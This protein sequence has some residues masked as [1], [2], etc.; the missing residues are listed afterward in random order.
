MAPC[1]RRSSTRSSRRRPV[2]R[3]RRDG[4]GF[5]RST[6][7]AENH[8]SPAGGR[9]APDELVALG[10]PCLLER[11]DQPL[12]R[13]LLELEDIELPAGQ[14][15]ALHFAEQG[16]G[17]GAALEGKGREHAVERLAGTGEAGAVPC[18]ELELA[19][20]TAQLAGARDVARRRVQATRK[21]LEHAAPRLLRDPAVAA[22]HE[23]EPLP[24][25][26]R[27]EVEQ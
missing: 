18:P 3:G 23:Q 13:L 27:S 10:K 14:Q 15:R 8:A 11:R 22:L 1:W 26:D 20:N 4:D 16:P 25:P 19:R 24:R 6:A 9:H 5:N 7:G 17:L 21:P 2:L 12:I